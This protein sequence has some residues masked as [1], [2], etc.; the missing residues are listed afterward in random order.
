MIDTIRA[1]CQIHNI[2]LSNFKPLSGG[3]INQVYRLYS[4]DRSYVLKINTLIPFENMFQIEARSLDILRETNSF[5]IPKVIAE[6]KHKAYKYLVLEYIDSQNKPNAEGFSH[7]LAKLHNVTSSN[8]G[9]EFDNYIGSLPQK[10]TMTY[11]SAS[12]FYINLRLEPQFKLAAE[13]GYT[14]KNLDLLYKTVEEIVPD[15]SPSLIH[16]DLWSGNYMYTSHKPAV[17]DPAISFAP[18][19]MDIAMMKLFGGFAPEIFKIYDQVFPFSKGWEER[20]QLWQLYYLLVH[21]NLF[22]QSYYVSVERII[23]NYT[24]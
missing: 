12:A 18:R 4:A 19:E 23:K 9:L 10:N 24:L 13:K 11:T 15:E 14:F 17:I 5:L 3:D 20:I 16:G 22:G 21:L 7:A 2:P 6:G 8:F 1:I